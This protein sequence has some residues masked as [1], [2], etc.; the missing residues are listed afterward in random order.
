[1][2]NSRDANIRLEAHPRRLRLVNVPA[3]GVS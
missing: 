2:G 3:Q 1:M